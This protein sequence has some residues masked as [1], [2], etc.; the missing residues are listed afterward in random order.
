MPIRKT[1]RENDTVIKQNVCSQPRPG[2][3][4]SSHK[5]SLC[6]RRLWALH[7]RLCPRRPWPTAISPDEGWLPCLPPI[8]ALEEGCHRWRMALRIR[9]HLHSSRHIIDH[10]PLPRHLASNHQP[11]QPHHQGCQLDH[12][13]RRPA[14][15]GLLRDLLLQDLDDNNLRLRDSRRHLRLALPWVLL[16]LVSYRLASSIRGMAEAG[17]LEISAQISRVMSSKR[18]VRLG[19]GQGANSH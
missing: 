7:L 15:V 11:L 6:R 4:I 8:L 10:P 16:H 18:T 3:T 13:R 19:T 17:E 14:M 1:A 9:M 12:H 2:S 5:Y